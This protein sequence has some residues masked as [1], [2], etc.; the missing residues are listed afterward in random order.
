MA[1]KQP[2]LQVWI[3]A[4]PTILQFLMQIF[5]IRQKSCQKFFKKLEEGV[6]WVYAIRTKRKEGFEKLAYGA[7]TDSS[8]K[9]QTLIYL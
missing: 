3:T 2:S 8:G 6:F 1:I 4:Q 5:K 9:L 7:F